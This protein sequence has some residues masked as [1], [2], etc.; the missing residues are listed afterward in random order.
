VCE[1][2]RDLPSLVKRGMHVALVPPP[3]KGTRFHDVE[4]CE[5]DGRSR[6][7]RLSGV[8]DLGAA[9][10]LVGKTVLASVDDLG[11]DLALKDVRS[12]LG[13]EVVDATYGALGTID[14]VMR[15]PA[16][17]VWSVSGRY[18]TVLVPAATELVEELPERGAI[19]MRLPEGL[20]DATAAA[21]DA[22]VT[23]AGDA[24][25]AAGDERGIDAL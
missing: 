22:T 11:D 5:G 8:D 21:G 23:A 24:P 20:V 18:G 16:N 25:A 3:L 12:L 9:H 7:V 13:R 14:E 4:R 10:E 15:G 1:A 2:A 17:D 19:R 6:L